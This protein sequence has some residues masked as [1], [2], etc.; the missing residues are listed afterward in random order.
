MCDGAGTKISERTG[1]QTIDNVKIL[2]GTD[3]REPN[4]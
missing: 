3:G 4:T 2:T 1:R